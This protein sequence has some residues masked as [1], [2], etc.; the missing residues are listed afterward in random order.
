[1]LLLWLV[2]LVLLVN[3]LPV[4]WGTPAVYAADAP[5]GIDSVNATRAVTDR[6]SF[7]NVPSDHKLELHVDYANGK[8]EKIKY[9]A[10]LCAPGT[11]ITHDL[12]LYTVKFVA[13]GCQ[14]TV[15]QNLNLRW[16]GACQFEFEHDPDAHIV[17]RGPYGEIVVADEHYPVG[18]LEL[19]NLPANTTSLSA[20]M[21]YT[22][23]Q[24]QAQTGNVEFAFHQPHPGC[25]QAA[26]PTPTSTQ[27]PTA[28]IETET[29]TS[30][31]TPTV[32]VETTTVTPTVTTGTATSTATP[33]PTV[34]T[35]TVTPTATPFS[36]VLPPTDLDPVSEPKAPTAVLYLPLLLK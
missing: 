15:F 22:N 32:I 10:A 25:G 33:T 23:E 36:A 7:Y 30:T 9:P 2:S 1:M 34:E 19:T 12:N 29:P 24:G 5:T 16:L 31:A 27:T 4:D 17:A 3:I 13:E 20:T 35:P 28:T 18:L 26:T 8:T 6:I 21:S 14:A 11:V